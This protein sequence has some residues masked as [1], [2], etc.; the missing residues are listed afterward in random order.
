MEIA[1]R[2]TGQTI[3]VDALLGG[4]LDRTA[5]IRSGEVEAIKVHHLGPRRHEVFHKLLLRVR[6]RIDFREGAQL[7]VRA[8]DQVDTGAG[9]LDLVR[10]PVTPLVHAFGASG[11]L[12]LRAHVEEV[13]EEVVCQRLW[14]LGE[15][16][17]FGL[18]EVSIQGPHAT[19][20]NCHL[21]GPRRAERVSVPVNRAL[22]PPPAVSCRVPSVLRWDENYVSRER[23]RYATGGQ[24]IPPC[25]SLDP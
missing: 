8:E 4:N 23:P 10:L 21:G 24:T 1:G 5:I 3:S 17:V 20:Q 15:D 9:P 19:D 22:W 14:P 12:P 25:R 16:A 6:A 13:G 2:V 11:R 18:P 7:R